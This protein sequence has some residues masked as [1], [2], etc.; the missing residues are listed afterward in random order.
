ME[1]VPVML[2][3]KWL[4]GSQMCGIELWPAPTSADGRGRSRSGLLAAS[5]ILEE[6]EGV[7]TAIW[8]W[9]LGMPRC[10]VSIVRNAE[11]GC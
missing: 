9:K 4:S 2:R 11:Q 10:S 1:I 6:E 3:E 5:R 8:S 7:C